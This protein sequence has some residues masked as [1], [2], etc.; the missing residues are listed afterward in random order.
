MVKQIL[1][2]ICNK[3]L[4]ENEIIHVDVHVKDLRI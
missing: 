1:P 4:K 3:N 2:T